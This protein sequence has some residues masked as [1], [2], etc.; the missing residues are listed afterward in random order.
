MSTGQ[1]AMRQDP[2][3]P[4]LWLNGDVSV[5]PDVR[6]GVNVTIY[7]PAVIES[8][9]EIQ[10]GAVVG[11]PPRLAATSRAPEIAEPLTTVGSG[12]AVCTGA[13]VFTGVSIG[14]GSIVGDQAHLREGTV[15]GS[16][17]VLGR[18]SAVGALVVI[19]D[20]VRIQTGVWIT[21]GVHVEDNVF[22]GPGVVTMNDD[23]M[24]QGA[25][26]IVLTPPMIRRGA[27]VGGGVLLT[28]G[29]EVGAG[30]FVAAGAVVTHDVPAGGRVAGV[31][32]RA[33]PARS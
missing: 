8:G 33:F 22:L 10:D 2:R 25:D 11:K 27:R 15:M 23:A 12:A 17:S 24:G 5:A 32:A 16:R 9:A 6:L 30:A 26:A 1:G 4:N 18:G 14:A 28:P 31:P 21:T 19:G 3:A 20:D 29:V 13:V 7:G